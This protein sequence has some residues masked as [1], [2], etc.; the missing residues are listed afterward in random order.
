MK[1]LT[2]GTLVIT[3]AF[4]VGF[5][6]GSQHEKSDQIG[7]IN[8]Q[9]IELQEKNIELSN[10]SG[11]YYAKYQEAVNRK[12][13]VITDRVYVKANCNTEDTNGSLGDGS[14][15][16]RVELHPET[17]RGAAKITDEAEQDMLRCL[18]ARNSLQAKIKRI[19][20]E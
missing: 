9:L 14:L 13:T 18:A 10:L 7:Q 1:W 17:V 11:D 12:P 15:G 5:K 6:L 3:L 2:L 4:T 8:K 20:N 16:T 19:N